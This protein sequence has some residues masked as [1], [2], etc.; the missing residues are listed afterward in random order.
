MNCGV[1]TAKKT[2][3]GLPPPPD[4][5]VF[6]YRID[7]RDRLMSANEDWYAFARENGVYALAAADVIGQSLDNFLCDEETKHLFEILIQ[8]VRRT[9]RTMVLPYRCDSPDCRR[10]M[11]LT[12]VPQASAEVEFHSRIIRQEWREPVRL[13][14][15]ETVRT[16]EKLVMC[17][18]CKKI[19]MPDDRWI[20]VEAAVGEL[21]LFAAPRL[22][23]IS[24]GICPQ[25]SAAISH[26]P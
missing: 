22:P 18:W 12:V 20:E 4:H 10:F 24:H 9:L 3:A 5:R 6:V 21:E 11:E 7:A 15:K 25:C 16:D 14:A 17:G 26:W 1:T 8:K 13:L 2:E 19:R 23:Q